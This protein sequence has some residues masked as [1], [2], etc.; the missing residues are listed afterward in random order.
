MKYLIQFILQLSILALIVYGSFQLYRYI[1][2]NFAYSDQVVNEI[3]ARVR[4]ECLVETA[5]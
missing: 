3:K 2:W 4:P 5:R 1:N